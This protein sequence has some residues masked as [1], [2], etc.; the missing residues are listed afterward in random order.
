MGGAVLFFCAIYRTNSNLNTALQQTLQNEYDF[1]VIPQKDQ[2]VQSK[3]HPNVISG[4]VKLVD[5]FYPG[6][7]YIGYNLNREFFKDKRV[8][9]ALSHAVPV[10]QIVDKVFHNLAVR[11]SGPFEVGSPGI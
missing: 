5:Y 7:R 9:W 3:T 6:Y 1:A 8:R 10:D 2:F 4:K 11:V